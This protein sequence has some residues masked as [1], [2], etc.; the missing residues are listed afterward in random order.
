MEALAGARKLLVGRRPEART[1]DSRYCA[2]CFKPPTAAAAVV[3]WTFATVSAEATTMVGA[4]E[5]VARARSTPGPATELMMTVE[6]EKSAARVRHRQYE[7]VKV[8]AGRKVSEAEKRCAVGR[9]VMSEPTAAA[10]FW[11]SQQ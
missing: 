9:D 2:N 4:S 8:S 10:M 6:W 11:S 5:R 7:F 3:L 1:R